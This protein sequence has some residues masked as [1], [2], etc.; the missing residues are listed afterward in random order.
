LV[1]RVNPGW[2]RIFSMSLNFKGK[3]PS[4]H[5]GKLMRSILMITALLFSASAFAQDAP[6]AGNEP[7]L[8]VKP[9]GP[10]GCKPLGTVGGTKLWAGDCAEAFARVPRRNE[11]HGPIDTRLPRR[12]EAREHI[13]ARPP[14]EEKT[15]WGR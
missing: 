10:V 1:L 11:A 13:D 8:Q 5:K 14:A 3:E 9:K 12:N 6:K 15:W 4:L 2:N 7:P